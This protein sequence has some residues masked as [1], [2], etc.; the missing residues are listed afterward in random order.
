MLEV[1]RGVLP[2]GS[3]VTEDTPFTDLGLGSLAAARVVVEVGI[4]LGVDLSPE[5]ARGCRDPRALAELALA[6]SGGGHLPVLRPDPGS[7]YEP[8]PLT[9]LQE[10]YLLGKSTGDGIGCHIYREYPV[11]RFDAG[12]VR[13]AWARLVDHHDALRLTVSDDGTQRVMREAPAWEFPVGTDVEATRAALAHRPHTVDDPLLWSVAATALPDGSGVLHLAIDAL[14]IDGAGLAL[15]VDQLRALLDDPEHSLPEPQPHLRDVIVA[16][17]EHSRTDAYRASLAALVERAREM[18]P[19]PALSPVTGSSEPHTCL[20]SPR[21]WASVRAAAATAEVSPTALVLTVFTEAVRRFTEDPAFTVVLTTNARLV[22]PS[23]VDAVVGPFTSTAFAVAGPSEGLP[24]ADAARRTHERLRADLDHVAVPGVAVQRGLRGRGP[25]PVVFTSLLELGSGASDGSYALSR[26]SGVAL[27]AQVAERDGGLVLRWD[28]V[29]SAFAPGAVEAAFAWFANTLRWLW[30]GDEAGA[31]PVNGLQQAYVV[32]RVTGG[33]GPWTGCQVAHGFTVDQL[34]LPALEAAWLG[35]LSDHEVL[36]TA[37]THEGAAVVHD[38]VP[39]G[40]RIPVCHAEPEAVLRDLAHRAFPLGRLP[41]AEVRVSAHGGRATVLVAIDLLVA[42]GRST[43]LLLR[44]LMRRYR[45]PS[46]RVVAGEPMAALVEHRRELRQGPGHAAAK[47]HW[48]DRVAAL[49]PGPPLAGAGPRTRVTAVIPGW[50]RVRQRA[51]R[52]GVSLD[53]VL[54]TALTEA[55]G[56]HVP[57]SFAVPLVRWSPAVERFRPAEATVLSWV[58]RPP[59]G[60]PFTEGALAAHELITADERADDAD[61]LAELR[62]HVLRNRGAGGYP[63]VCTG[64]L[65]LAG[66]PLPEGVAAAGWL[67]CTPD[68]ALDCIAIDEGGDDLAVFWDATDGAFPPDALTHVFAAYRVLLERLGAEADE[69]GAPCGRDAARHR[70]L[71]LANDTARPFPHDGPVHRLFEAQAAAHP[72]AVAV[73]HRGGTMTYGELNAAANRV[74]AALRGLG[75]GPGS[76][77]GIRMART[78]QLVAA[79]YGVLKAGGAYL[80]VEPSLPVERA[81]VML[82]DGAAAAVVTTSDLAGATGLPEVCADQLGG[83]VLGGDVPEGEALTDPDPGTD[84]D[85]TAYVIFTSGSTGRPKGV[86]VA[87]RA[88]HNLLAWAGREFGFGPAD[89]GLCVT[90]LG[91]DLSV[92]D[93]LCLPAWG[94]SVYLADVEQQRDPALLLDVLLD[95]PITFWNSAPTTL[96]HLAPLLDAHVGDPR[97]AGLRLAFL[98]GDYTPLW[99]PDRLRACFRAVDLIS[100]GG[101]TEATVWSNW[102][103]VG[104]VDPAWRSIPYGKPI[105]NARYYVLD[106]DLRPCGVEEEGDLFIAGEVLSEGYRNR[107]ELTDERFTPC[108]YDPPGTRM[109]RTGD[110][111]AFTGTGDLV[112]LGRADHQV[113]I[114]G[115]R[116]ELGEVEHRLRAHP[117]VADAVAVTRDD[118]GERKLVAYVVPAPGA[119]PTAK[120]LRA[121][122]GAALPDYMVPNRVGVVA[123]F[124]ATSNGKLDRAA[125]PWPPPA[126]PAAPARPDARELVLSVLGELIGAEVDPAVDLWDQGA[127]SFTMVR[128][129]GRVHDAFGVRIPVS[130]LLD[131]P[132]VDGIVAHLGVPCAPPAEVE[133]EPEVVDVLSA[134]AKEGFAA[135]RKDLRAD[136]TPVPLPDNPADAVRCLLRG[137]RRDFTADAVPFADLAALLGLLRPADNGLRR[138]PSAGSTYGVQFYVHVRAGRVS[139]VEPGVYYYHPDEHALRRLS[140]GSQLTRSAHFLY[141]RPVHDAAAFELFLV[142]ETRA[143]RPLYA[144]DTERFLALEAGYAGQLLM[145][146]QALFGLGL[147]PIGSVRAE[148]VRDALDLGAD[149]VFLQSFLGGVVERVRPPSAREEIAVV[150]MAGRYPGAPDLETLWRNLSAGHCAVGAAERPGAPPGGYLDD[151]AGFD[152][153]VFGIAPAEGEALDPQLRQLLEVVWSCLEDAAHTPASLG[154]VGVFVGLMW[155]DHRLLGTDR[156]RAGEAATV[157]GTGSEVA[158]RVSHAFDF[159]GPSL[160]VDTA[161]SSSLTALRLAVDSLRAGDCDAAV[162]GAANLLLHPYHADVLR[163]LGLV[164]AAPGRAFDPEAG[165]WSPGE[166]VGALLLRRLPDARADGDTVH[167]VIESAWVSHGGGTSRF[168]TPDVAELRRS[169]ADALRDAGREPEDIGYVECAASGAALSDAAEV[170]ALGELFA[171]HPVAVGTVKPNVGHAEAA[172]GLAQVTKVLLQLRHRALAPSLVARETGLVDLGALPLRFPAE[173]EPWPDAAAR[174]LVTAVGATGSAGHVVLRAGDA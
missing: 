164:A 150:G 60:R 15:L 119:A 58:P 47:A 173:A 78:P 121:H 93:L 63:V 35:L 158:N 81:G 74:A 76:V 166:G 151:V 136:G 129:S 21:E 102:F 84:E 106:D 77:V 38:A 50:S 128:L 14:I 110:R 73:R 28:V 51:Q 4:A 65:E 156:W 48:K 9:P 36:R 82:G 163:G 96:A 113:K 69:W 160:A 111:A 54:I 143:V 157:S 31:L 138:Y 131:D 37:V 8:F 135:A 98:S 130:A 148:P 127:T 26:T 165:G 142:G 97:A 55:L 170:Q 7:R 85:A 2:P 139:G 154:R 10:A 152:S 32:S 159:R 141:N 33:V 124:P 169:L 75:V 144:E 19:G 134:E 153:A 122:V 167:G 114:R 155:H 25:F 61:G 27:D 23:A 72:D 11:T 66:S 145:D 137:S 107:P 86:A 59:E 17:D 45:D 13:A 30:P 64:L 22:L 168:G 18:P 52:L 70:T 68:V 56:V 171:G 40:W 12:R 43:H 1:V 53:A 120:E 116:V 117:A 44:E 88:V 118:G 91:F 89:V 71:R 174:A 123:A 90:S 109:Y 29:A 79:V 92:F 24:L 94:A 100:L 108:P 67:T 57:G 83:D 161:C 80:P 162:V 49:P 3:R 42:D 20:L 132:T 133:P 149:H 101:A 112:F 99:L 105:D 6:G 46:A 140:D 39:D 104:E 115:F 16:L 125:L 126:A 34:D 87:H 172:S 62:A 5:A 146:N 103:R 95:E 41:R 147:C